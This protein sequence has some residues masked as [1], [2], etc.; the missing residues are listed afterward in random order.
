MIIQLCDLPSKTVLIVLVVKIFVHS[1]VKSTQMRKLYLFRKKPFPTRPKIAIFKT[2]GIV[3]DYLCKKFV[4]QRWTTIDIERLVT[5]QG[6][7]K[8]AFP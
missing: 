6:W 8:C 2:I 5:L 3:I 1:V 4:V 7:P